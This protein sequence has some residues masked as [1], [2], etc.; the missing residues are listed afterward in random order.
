MNEKNFKL[1]EGIIS[2]SYVSQAQQASRQRENLLTELLAQRRLPEEGWDDYTIQC[3]LRDLSQMDS[4]NFIENVGVGDREARVYSSIVRDRH[5]GLAH[6]LGRSGDLLAEQPKAAGSSLI[7]KLAHYLVKDILKTSGLTT[8]KSC[9]IVPMA[10]TMTIALVLMSLRQK[11]PEARFVL[12]PRMDQKACFK[13]IYA[14]GLTPIVIPNVLQ[15]DEIR[16]DLEEL[17]RVIA[18]RGSD[19]ILAVL[20]TT[21]CFAP[22]APDRIIEI[23]IQ[24]AKWD[25][26]HVINNA[27]GLQST[28]CSHLIV[29]SSRL[30]RVDAFVQSTDKNLLVPVGGAIVAACSSQGES[31]LREISQLYPGRASVSPLLDVFITA[32][33]MGSSGY[34]SL[35]RERKE[36]FEFCKNKMREVMEKYGEKVLDTPNNPFS[37]AVTLRN[38]CIEG[39]ATHIGSKLFTRFV[40]GVRVVDGKSSKTINGVTFEGYESH[41]DR[42]PHPYFTISCTIGITKEDIEGFIERL[43]KDSQPN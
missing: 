10:T 7:S 3:V 11:K 8:V 40:S 34:K 30:G 20:S 35:L 21:S 1:V 33:S 6:G 16:T 4:N 14:A 29:E 2:R 26:G 22:R 28:R 15:D 25:I 41:I 18:E 5:F 37:M 43:D 24:C 27:Y 9:L 32:L 36:M 31:I 23:A 13:S 42:Y 17:E 19:Q 39:S 38:Y 12:F